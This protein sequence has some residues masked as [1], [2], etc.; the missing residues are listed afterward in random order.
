MADSA[1]RLFAYKQTH[2]TGF[3]PNPFHGLCTLATC[4]PKIR[5][6]KRVGDWIAGFTSVQLT[7]GRGGVGEEMLIYLMRVTEKLSL[8]QY[9]ADPRF[10]AK[11][12]S[13]PDDA[14]A[15]C[16][17]SVGDNIYEM[18]DGQWIQHPNRSHKPHD[19]PKDTGGKNVLIST[20]FWYFGSAPLGIPDEFRPCVPTFQAAGGVQTKDTARAQAFIDHVRTQRPGIHARP[21]TWKTGDESWRQL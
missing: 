1:I 3:A 4:K 8:E 9:F 13:H 5:E 7:K 14:S 17:A 12:P 20:D 6:H 21:H 15:P 2:D 11:K 16:L 18:C 10:S 19:I